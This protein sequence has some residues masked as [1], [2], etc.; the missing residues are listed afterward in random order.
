MILRLWMVV[1]WYLYQRTDRTPAFGGTNFRKRL[2]QSGLRVYNCLVS[3]AV[4]YDT[5]QAACPVWGLE[6]C[7]K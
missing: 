2:R 1:P 3:V 4:S 6:P 5:L 7:S